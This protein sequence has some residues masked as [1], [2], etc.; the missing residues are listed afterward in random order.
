MQKE[1]YY[2]ITLQSIYMGRKLRHNVRHNMVKRCNPFA[3]IVYER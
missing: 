2:L 1:Q 3:A